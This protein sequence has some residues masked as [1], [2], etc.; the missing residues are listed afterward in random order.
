MSL[1]GLIIVI[2]L[3]GLLVWAVTELIPMPQPFK[4]AIYVVAVV[5]LVL[6]VLQVFG[7]LPNLN[8]RLN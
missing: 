6:Y 8:P 4:K 5:F 2:A 3:C 7:V 1:F